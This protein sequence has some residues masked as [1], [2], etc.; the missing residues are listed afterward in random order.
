MYALGAYIPSEIS[1]CT[2]F[3]T[4]YDF[5]ISK[6][7]YF[8]QYLT[9]ESLLSIG[10]KAALTYSTPVSTKLLSNFHNYLY[11]YLI[12]AKDSKFVRK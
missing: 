12:F 11:I 4:F 6:E 10:T 9:R 7:C 8:Q 5:M 2:F 3:T 1:D